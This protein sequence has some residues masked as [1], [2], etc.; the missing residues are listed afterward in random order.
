MALRSP[1]TYFSKRSLPMVKGLGVGLALGDR[2]DAPPLWC[3][4]PDKMIA[5]APDPLRGEELAQSGGEEEEEEAQRAADCETRRTGR[6]GA[7]SRRS[8]SAWERGASKGCW[9]VN[10]NEEGI[11]LRIVI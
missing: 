5:C 3:S 11:V 6:G 1:N 4:W 7:P 2:R 10:R 9:Y 8:S